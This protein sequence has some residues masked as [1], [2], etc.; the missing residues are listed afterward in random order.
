MSFDDDNDQIDGERSKEKNEQKEEIMNP[1]FNKFWWRQRRRGNKWDKD[2]RLRIMK[3]MIQGT[4]MIM[5]V[6]RK[7]KEMERKELED[8]N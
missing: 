2:E 3:I 4:F 5:M 7:K 1:N 6:M 8:W